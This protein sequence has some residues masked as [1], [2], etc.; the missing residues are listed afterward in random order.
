MALERYRPRVSRTTTR[1]AALALTAALVAVAGCSLDRGPDLEEAR[2]FQRLPIYWLGDAFEGY[3]LERIEG[4]EDWAAAVVLIYGDCDPGFGLQPSCAPPVQI[5]IFPLCYH[6][7]A[8]AVGHGKRLRTVRG[9]P[10]GTQDGAPVLLTRRA[11]V[12]VYRGQGTDPRV[13]RRALA[14]LRSL[15]TVEP[16]VGVD[17]PIPPPLPG[18]LEGERPCSS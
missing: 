15:N 12:K 3:D 2:S 18:V 8:V 6:L 10:L 11:Q 13:A 4:L 16:V 9:A 1:A 7:D 14:A 17:D 5:Q